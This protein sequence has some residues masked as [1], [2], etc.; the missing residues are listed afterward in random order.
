MFLNY[1]LQKLYL[2][3]VEHIIRLLQHVIS[4]SEVCGVSVAV[5]SHVRVSTMFL[6]QLVGTY[7]LQGRFCL[8]WQDVD[9]KLRDN[10]S[11]GEEK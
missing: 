5:T 11:N 6:L 10:R 3:K 1:I 9:T 2:R 4:D 8:L 7:K